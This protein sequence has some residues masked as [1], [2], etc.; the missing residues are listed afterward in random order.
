MITGKGMFVWKIKDVDHCSL[1]DFPENFHPEKAASMAFDAGFTHVLVKI[2]DGVWAYNQ[3]P[4]YDSAGRKLYKD[5]ILRLFVE[6]F[7]AV[8]IKVIGWQYIYFTSWSPAINEARKANTR[9]KDL[10]LDGF[11]IDAEGYAKRKPTDT[12]NYMDNLDVGVPVALSTYRYPVVHPEISYKTFLAGCDA[13]MPQV[14]WEF[15]HNAGAQLEHSYA[16]WT[17]LLADTGLPKLPYIPTG[18]AYSRTTWSATSADVLAFL[19]T[20]VA[21]DK[22]D[23]PLEVPG[24]NF[25][26][27]QSAKTLGLWDFIA[28]FPW[29]TDGPGPTPSEVGIHEWVADYLYPWVKEKF[30]FSG[31][32]PVR[33]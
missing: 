32:K 31:P 15:A 11:V 12:K 10:G 8:G 24:V 21:I 25:W 26:V 13:V 4:Y 27:W 7:Q 2:L 33:K 5:D 19:Q 16:Q 20:A 9:V 17:K 29:P 30:G 23:L 1:K 28:Q 18:A 3:R 14:Y 6:A 22:A